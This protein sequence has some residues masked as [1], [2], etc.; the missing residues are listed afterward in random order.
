MMYAILVFGCLYLSLVFW[1]FF[2]P[3]VDGPPSAVL[4]ACALLC[5]WCWRIYR[6]YCDRND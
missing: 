3:I 1:A 6:R 4:I 5:A 2:L